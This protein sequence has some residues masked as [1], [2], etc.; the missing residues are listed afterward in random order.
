MNRVVVTGMGAVT[1]LGNDVD[2]FLT[3]LLNSKVG[4]NKITKFDAEATGISVAGEV[5]DFDAMKRLDRKTAKRNGL[6]VNYALYSAHEA[7]EM[8]GLNEDNIKPEELGVIYGSGIGGLTTI[9]E[10]VIKMHDKGPKR[11]SPLFVPNSIVNM[12]A[13]DIS[14]AF[15]A[16]NTSQ[17]IVTACSSGTNAIGNAFEYIK[18]GKAEAMIAGGT[19]ASVNEIGISGFAAITALSKTEDPMKASIPFDKDRNGFVMGEGSGTLVLES[20][21]HAKARGAKILA[22]IVG[23]GTTSDAYHMTAPD[24]EGTGAKRAMQMA[25]DE[26]EIDATDVDYINAHG[27]STHANDSAESKA[28][29]V[30]FSKNDHV[31][32]SSTKGM[33]GHALGAA[34][35]IEAVATIGA[36][37]RNQM[38]V[39]VGVVNQDEECDV[40]LVD[41]TNKKTTVNYAIS[42]S[43]GF[44]GHNAVIAFKGCD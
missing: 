36:I 28:I 4:I 42:N 27:T 37:Q 38:P 13:G 29:N 12:A 19:E 17:A 33:T 23:Y 1:P 34:G 39:N 25:I 11:V 35:A 21:D 24:P 5:K 43:F 41:D 14:I 44:G 31:K 10:Q 15:K 3:N 7:M 18:E 6:F 40:D 16:R 30:V 26:A 8:A 9:Q 2:S 20:Y 32:V 22:E